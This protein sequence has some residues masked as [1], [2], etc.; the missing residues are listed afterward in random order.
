MKKSYYFIILLLIGYSPATQA[1]IDYQSQVQPIFNA[2]CTSCHGANGGVNLS[3]FSALMSSVGNSYGSNVVVPGDP[4]A[5]GLIDKLGTNPQFGNPMPPSG[6]LSQADI[7]MIRQWIS[8]GANEVPTSNEIDTQI[9]T[10]FRLIGNYPNP[11]N[12]STQIQFELPESAQYTIS[13]FSVHGQL[14]MEEVGFASAGIASISVDMQTNP[15]GVYLYQVSAVVNGQTNMI[16]TGRM[17][18]IK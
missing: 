3:S 6:Q 18:L 10:S 11:F 1:Q 17:T 8:E 16:G 5:S 4:Q 13:I 14:L 12:P 7:A 9:P 15:T 2:N